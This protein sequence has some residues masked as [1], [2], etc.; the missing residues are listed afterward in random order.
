MSVKG[1]LG[2]KVGMTQ[3][4]DAEGKVIP[5]T[6]LAVEPNVDHADQDRR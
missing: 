6:V 1:L 2:K 5:V 4:F 3:V